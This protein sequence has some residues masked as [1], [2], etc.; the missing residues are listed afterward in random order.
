MR[1]VVRSGRRGVLASQ[2]VSP[3]EVIGGRYKEFGMIARVEIGSDAAGAG[4][5]AAAAAVIKDE[6]QQASQRLKI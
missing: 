3:L 6:P 2:L 5:R 4:H 1:D